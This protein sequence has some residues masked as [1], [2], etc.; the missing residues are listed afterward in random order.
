MH[1]VP[2][3]RKV[4]EELRLFDAQ[5]LE[6]EAIIT[7]LDSTRDSRASFYAPV[8]WKK[9]H[10][11]LAQAL[12]RTFEVPF[13]DNGNSFDSCFQFEGRFLLGE[14]HCRIKYYWKSLALLQSETVAKSLGMNTKALYFPSV[15]MGLALAESR[16]EGQSRIEI[17]YTANSLVAEDE[18]L[19]PIFHERAK[20]DLNKAERALETVSGLGWHLPLDELL[21]KFSETTRQHQLLIVQPTLVAMIYAANA[22]S[23]CFTGFCKVRTPGRYFN[24][25][26]FLA[27]QALPGPDSVTTC[28]L[29]EHGP[30]GSTQFLVLEK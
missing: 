13:S 25:Q 6:N 14:L 21:K 26:E 29:Q 3:L 2:I 5:N 10:Q 16:N 28:I 19:H 12:Q 4:A 11:E 22:K 23:N 7:K 1:N 30:T 20:D 17:T 9:K 27:A 18:I 24:Y 15:R 8:D